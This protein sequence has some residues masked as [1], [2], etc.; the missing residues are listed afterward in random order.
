[1]ANYS[2]K[3]GESAEAYYKRLAKVADQRLVRLEALSHEKGFRSVKDWSYSTAMDDIKKFLPAGDPRRAASDYLR[4]NTKVTADNVNERTADVIKFLQKPTSNRRDIVKFYKKRA[5]SINKNA[6]TNFTWQQLADFF[7]NEKVKEFIGTKKYDSGDTLRVY[8]S[9]NA[10]EVKI[11]KPDADIPEHETKKQREARLNQELK[12]AL[13]KGEL[14]NIIH[15]E[16][17]Q[18]KDVIIDMLQKHDLSPAEVVS[19]L[20]K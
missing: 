1:M 6:N 8:N 16:D 19:S 11:S 4:F 2:K 9:F 18:V 20:L 13:E 7:E 3:P 10:G 12:E 14:E 5:D 17:E 15:V